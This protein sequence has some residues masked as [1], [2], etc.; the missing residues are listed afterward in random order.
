VVIDVQDDDDE[1]NGTTAYYTDFFKNLKGQYNAGLV[2][3]NAIGAFDEQTNLPTSTNC[4][5]SGEPSGERYY[6]VAQGTGGKTW[7]VCNANWGDVANQ[8]AL[9]AFQG[10]K[11]FPLSR[12]ADPSTI[13]VTMNGAAQASGTDYTFDQPSNSIIFANAP[14]PGATIVADYTAL[15]L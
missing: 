12:T 14:P 4:A 13:K 2:S 6:E 8:L 1:S 11:Q 3:F 7:S 9:G 5:S 15:C 10:R